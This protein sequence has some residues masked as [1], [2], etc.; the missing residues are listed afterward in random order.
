MAERPCPTGLS[1]RQSPVCSTLLRAAVT[2]DHRD[3]A[4]DRAPYRFLAAARD[5]AVEEGAID[6]IECERLEAR[7][8][9][10]HRRGQDRRGR[11][12]G[13]CEPAET[14]QLTTPTRC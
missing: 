8:D 5:D 11:G 10:R 12:W 13:H 6:H 1:R 14:A 9:P 4:R 2:G 7:A 3:V